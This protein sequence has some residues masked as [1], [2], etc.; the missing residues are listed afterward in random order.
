MSIFNKADILLPECIDMKKWSV[1]ACD[2]YTSEP[3]YWTAVEKTVG[4]SESTFRLTV[5]EI[6]LND[7][8]I[9]SRIKNTNTKM[10]EYA[11]NGVFEEYKNTYMFVERTLA[12]GVK[13]LGVVGCVDLEDYDYSVGSQTK[14]RATEG[15]VVSRIPPRLKVRCEALI[16]LPHIMM[17][18]D[19]ENCGIIEPNAEI[20]DSFEKVYDFPPLP[21]GWESE[22]FMTKDEDEEDDVKPH[23]P[24]TRLSYELTPD[25]DVWDFYQY[26]IEIFREFHNWV[27]SLPKIEE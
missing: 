14:I 18:I 16:E 6:F 25:I 5:P 10:A 9:E 11:E 2:Q 15:T 26:Q 4:D 13:R 27:K 20:K 22:V 8:D 21:A 12:N 23:I 3:D 7:A 24:R 1:V 17:L 19:D